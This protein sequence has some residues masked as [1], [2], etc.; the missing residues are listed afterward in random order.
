MSVEENPARQ[1]ESLSVFFAHSPAESR[2]AV[3]CTRCTYEFVFKPLPGLLHSHSTPQNIIPS[4]TEAIQLFISEAEKEVA[5]C[6]DEIS[7]LKAIIAKIEKHQVIL[8]QGHQSTISSIQPQTEI[9]AAEAKENASDNRITVSCSSCIYE[10]ILPSLN[11]LNSDGLHQNGAETFHSSISEAQAEEEVMRLW[12]IIE[13]V[14]KHQSKLSHEIS[15]HQLFVSPIRRL[16]P[17]L[18]ALIFS[19]FCTVDFW[20]CEPFVSKSYR[21]RGSIFREPFIIATVCSHWR[22]IALSTPS[23]WST[24]MLGNMN[25]SREDCEA[26]NPD[27]KLDE[28]CTFPEDIFEVALE[29]SAQH[30]LK[31]WIERRDGFYWPSI[32]T[33]KLRQVCFRV[34]Q[35]YLSGS[36][37]P[38]YLPNSPSLAFDRLSAIHLASD[39]RS[40]DRLPWLLTAANVR[41]LVI[42]NVEDAE[43]EFWTDLPV[44]STRFLLFQTSDYMRDSE[45]MEILTRFPNI[46]SSGF[47][48]EFSDYV[49][50]PF[51]WEAAQTLHHLNITLKCYARDCVHTSSNPDDLEACHC[52]ENLLSGI[53][54]PGLKSLRLEA[55]WSYPGACWS[56]AHF[57]GF[58]DRSTIRESLTSLYL[59]NIDGLDDDELEHLFQSVPFLT[60]LTVSAFRDGPII[61]AP[62]LEQIGT[63]SLLPRLKFFDV[64]IDDTEDAV[65]AVVNLV[66]LRSGPTGL[67]EI[68][69]RLEGLPEMREKLEEGV[70]LNFAGVRYTIAD[71]RSA[72]SYSQYLSFNDWV[73]EIQR[74]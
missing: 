67:E 48:Y 7:R 3:S 14:K 55:D 57:S 28:S 39:D 46:T 62:I 47:S 22:S 52:F 30:P 43:P 10:F 1:S 45:A 50:L 38:F 61:R 29:R 24:I 20:D 13:L 25:M 26:D 21:I 19:L 58:L 51:A 37:D 15:I 32:L 9:A 60:R 40:M 68:V 44:Q 6:K 54:T 18:L 4:D 65:D 23:L 16:P 69:V 33:T 63:A 66:R 64:L 59:H 36:L 2:I 70:K 12:G 35:I 31:L 41:V 27:A 42:Q 34:Q 74:A 11:L 5:R 8:N 73:N 56:Q 72:R 53:T 71:P 49:V 17:E